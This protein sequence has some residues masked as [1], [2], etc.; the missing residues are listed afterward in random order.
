M[1]RRSNP[2]SM[3]NLRNLADRPA[4]E[5]REIATKGGRARGAQ[6]RQQKMLREIVRAC[7]EREVE[8]ET[9]EGQRE[10]VG[11]DVALVLSMYRQAIVEGNVRA[12]E[13][14]AKVSG[15]LDEKAAVSAGLVIQVGDPK[16]AAELHKAIEE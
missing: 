11:Y 9:M 5:V 2:R 13:Y 16:L 12:A 4:D 10:R 3:E 6:Q 8:I 15:A 14:I 7:A 1:A